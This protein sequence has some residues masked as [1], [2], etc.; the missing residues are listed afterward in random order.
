M[1]SEIQTLRGDMFA[2][3]SLPELLARLRNYDAEAADQ[4]F[5]HFTHQLLALA[6][7]HL[8]D[9][10]RGKIDPEDIVQSV[11]RSFVGRFSADRLQ[12]HN[13]DALWG[14]LS[15]MTVRKCLR[16]REYLLAASRDVRREV[17][18][19]NDALLPIPSRE[20]LPEDAAV[21]TDLVEN[22]LRGLEPR[23]REIV[24]LYLQGYS[25]RE[26]SELRD[27]AYRTVRRIID[28][29]RRRLLRLWD[30]GE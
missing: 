27:C 2:Q 8:D 3:E 6:R 13:W 25:L 14:L 26:I 24:V 11:Y 30:E 12:L 10:A 15:L 22:L 4:L 17:S 28:R 23:D 29:A 5:D 18:L 19:P 16:R 21:L 7:T 1:L 9:W 20:P